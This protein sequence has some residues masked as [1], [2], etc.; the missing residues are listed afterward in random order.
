LTQR[1]GAIQKT[2]SLKVCELVPLKAKRRSYFACQ[3]KTFSA[4]LATQKLIT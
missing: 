2:V 3:E 4:R 1:F